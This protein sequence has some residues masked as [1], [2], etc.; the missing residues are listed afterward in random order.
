M[1]RDI[2]KV[3]KEFMKLHKEVFS[4]ADLFFMNTIPFFLTLSRVIYF[5]AVNHLASRATNAIFRAFKE[6]YL[7]YLHR[8]F[9][10][11][12]IHADGEFEALK[13]LIEVLPGRPFVNLASRNEHVPEIE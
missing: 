10:I 2:I 13:P 8:G 11:T 7:Y 9:R 12:T 6:I 1:V 3:P 5:T 4:T